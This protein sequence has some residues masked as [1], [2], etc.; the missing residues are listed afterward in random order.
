MTPEERLLEAVKASMQ[1]PLSCMLCGT[2]THNRGVFIPDDKKKK[3]YGLKD[4][5]ATRFIIYP[6]CE[7][8]DMNDEENAE[9]V[10]LAILDK[11]RSQSYTNYDDIKGEE[12]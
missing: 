1:Y 8:H 2:I 4:N 11:V 9:K 5:E 12:G 3:M 6:L 7:A 10:E